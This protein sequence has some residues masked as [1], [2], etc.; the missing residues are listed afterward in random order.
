MSTGGI[1][2]SQHV[3]TAEGLA[4]WDFSRHRNYGLGSLVSDNTLAFPIL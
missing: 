3:A 4:G 2:Q 1:G